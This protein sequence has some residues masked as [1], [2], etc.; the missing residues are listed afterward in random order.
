VASG[1]DDAYIELVKMT[2]EAVAAARVASSALIATEFGAKCVFHHTLSDI[3]PRI[4]CRCQ[5]TDSVDAGIRRELKHRPGDYCS[6]SDLPEAVYAS[7]FSRL[8]V[9]KQTAQ[10][11]AREYASVLT[12]TSEIWNRA[13]TAAFED[14]KFFLSPFVVVCIYFE[15]YYFL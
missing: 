7:I 3:V 8:A 11:K 1:L 6:G 10:Q 14:G 5:S 12:L 9:M 2:R 13:A 15:L 4:I